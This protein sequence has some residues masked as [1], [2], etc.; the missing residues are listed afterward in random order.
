MTEGAV[1]EAVALK[2]AE[3]YNN[4]WKPFFDVF[5]RETGLTLSEAI[6]FRHFM[7][8]PRT[9]PGFD[10]MMKDMAKEYQHDK[11]WKPDDD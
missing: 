3:R 7:A 10:D 8:V 9:P 2:W 11:K 4:G 6:A 1:Q 5:C